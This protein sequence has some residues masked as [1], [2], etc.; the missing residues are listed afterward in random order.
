[1]HASTACLTEPLVDEKFDVAAGLQNSVL[2]KRSSTALPPLWKCSFPFG[3]RSPSN[4]FIISDVDTRLQESLND[5]R[6][7]KS[8]MSASCP[9]SVTPRMM[10]ASAHEHGAFLHSQQR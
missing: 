7:N 10:H 3:L 4:H 8:T 2:L 5:Q 6:N 9:N 1:M